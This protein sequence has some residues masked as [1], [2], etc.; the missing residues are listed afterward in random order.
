[1]QGEARL[2]AVANQAASTQTE[3]PAKPHQYLGHSWRLCRV[4]GPEL[5]ALAGQSESNSTHHFGLLTFPVPGTLWQTSCSKTRISELG[6]GGTK[7]PCSAGPAL[8]QGGKQAAVGQDCSES[9]SGIQLH[10]GMEYWKIANQKN[11]LKKQL[12]KPQQCSES[13][14]LGFFTKCFINFCF[15]PPPSLTG[16]DSWVFASFRVLSNA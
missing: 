4:R 11:G 5:L 12:H 16:E 14:L 1:M 7:L 15:P 3:L 10:C 2:P 9:A 13:F 6:E 8:G